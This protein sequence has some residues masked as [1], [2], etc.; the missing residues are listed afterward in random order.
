MALAKNLLMLLTGFRKFIMGIIALSFIGIFNII[1]LALF[2]VGWYLG[3]VLIT[4]QQLVELWN[5]SFT[6]VGVIIGGF[7]AANICTKIIGATKE[8][9]MKKK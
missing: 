6:V 8:W 1:L 9:I 5:G 4:G 7:M 3:N 2:I